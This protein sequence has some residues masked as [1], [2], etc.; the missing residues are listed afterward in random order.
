[1]C[2]AD[3]CKRYDALPTGK[4]SARIE[5]ECLLRNAS[6]RNINLGLAMPYSLPIEAAVVRRWWSMTEATD[7]GR[8]SLLRA[9]SSAQA[10]DRPIPVSTRRS[11]FALPLLCSLPPTTTSSRRP[12]PRTDAQ[13]YKPRRQGPPHS[14]GR[15]RRPRLSPPPRP[16]LRRPLVHLERLRW[17]GQILSRALASLSPGSF[18]GG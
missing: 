17:R 7:G 8:G 10:R 9:L 14:R 12:P 5:H 4:P 16:A 3:K 1:M 13:P 6:R 15:S 18:L 11:T 2:A